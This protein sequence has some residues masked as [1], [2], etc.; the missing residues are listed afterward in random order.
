MYTHKF[1]KI[2]GNCI[3][4][5]IHQ[6]IRQTTTEFCFAFTE[7]SSEKK[8]KKAPNLQAIPLYQGSRTKLGS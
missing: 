6:H 7:D 4:D 5:H 8:R 2:G 1:F 3:E